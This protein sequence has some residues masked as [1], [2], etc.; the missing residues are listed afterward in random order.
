MKLLMI[1]IEEIYPSIIIKVLDILNQ[2][3]EYIK[4]H[5]FKYKRFCFNKNLKKNRRC[6]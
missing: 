4:Y 1:L 3:F 2:L 5:G 6:K